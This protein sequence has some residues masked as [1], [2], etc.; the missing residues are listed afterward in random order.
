MQGFTRNRMTTALGAVAV[1]TVFGALWYARSH[2]AGVEADEPMKNVPRPAAAAGSAPAKG[3][4]TWF[5]STPRADADKP[6]ETLNTL[7][8]RINEVERKSSEQERQLTESNRTI[9]ELRSQLDLRRRQDERNP[10]AA[11]AP[12]SAASAAGSSGG[13][14]TELDQV[15]KDLFAQGSS[16]MGTLTG[17]RVGQKPST[18][19]GAA[20]APKGVPPGL[21]FDGMEAPAA[22]QRL[23]LAP[24]TPT[25]VLPLGYP[26]DAKGQ[27]VLVQA[28]AQ[29]DEAEGRVASSGTADRKKEA[30]P[31]FTIP[32]NATLTRV[33]AMTSI[34]GRV[35]IDG[36]V[37]DPMKF[38]AIIGRENLAA[39]GFQV[40][41]D[42]AGIVVSGIAVGDMA[43][44]CSE[45]HVYSLT[46][47]FD[48]GSIRTVS[49]KPSSG[50]GGSLRDRSLGYISDLHG[51]PCIAGQFVTNAPSVLTD[52]VLAR[53]SST[54]ARAYAAAQTTT[55]DNALTGNTTSAV[56]GSRGAYVLG[57][58]AASGV[59]EVT[60]WLTSRLRNSFDA[61]VTRAGQKV[62]LHI[63][64]EIAI[65]KPE[66]PRRLDHTAA[67]RRTVGERHGL[68]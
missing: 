26:T 38:K 13:A 12:A 5:A 45:G 49:S 41:D 42:V 53:G 14:T 44:S 58:V 31:Y 50:G 29:A 39:N 43:L 62:V 15:A 37:Q 23:G 47:V 52:I 46:F 56:T 36:R 63:E 2:S 7:M 40:P 24:S 68:D 9:A 48:D 8:A 22:G 6:T 18:A 33:T 1:A 35:P 32:E 51:N 65:D 17:G 11:A 67:L 10:V 16:V 21:G 4:G 61:V 60:N 55:T 19:A 59:D 27:P 20:N 66:Q 25:T 54:A 64:R 28:S 34:V 3:K 30:T 57:Q